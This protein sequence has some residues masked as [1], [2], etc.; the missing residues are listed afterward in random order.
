MLP[1]ES[2]P[3]LLHIGMVVWALM[4]YRMKDGIRD[5]VRI[6]NALSDALEV[7]HGTIAK[8]STSYGAV[9][10]SQSG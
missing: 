5:S 1:T 3:D 6:R 8:D 9:E 7:S 4:I 10:S 2:A